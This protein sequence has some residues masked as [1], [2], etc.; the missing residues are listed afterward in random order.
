MNRCFILGSEMADWYTI[1][2]QMTKLGK[3]EFKYT[4]K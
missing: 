2:P 1:M 3:N 4:P